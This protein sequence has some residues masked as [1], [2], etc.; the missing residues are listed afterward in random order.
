[1][2]LEKTSILLGSLSATFF[3]FMQKEILYSSLL[4]L[5]V[6]GLLLV[7]RKRSPHLQ[8]GLLALV[9][10]RLLLPPDFSLAVSARSLFDLTNVHLPAQTFWQADQPESPAVHSGISTSSEPP[11]QIQIAAAKV[12]SVSTEAQS[13]PNFWLAAIFFLWVLGVICLS[14]VFL[15][16]YFYYRRVIKQGQIIDDARFL[17]LVQNWRGI[18]GIKRNVILLTSSECL[19]PFT[20]GLWR[21]VIY[22]P[23]TMLQN[24]SRET[25]E[26][27]IAHEMAHINNLD[28]L[29]IKFQNIVQILYFFH[30]IVW[31][32]NSRL[33]E[34]RE[35]LCDERVL[36]FGRITP[37]SYGN[38]MLA[39]LKLNLLGVEGVEMLPSFGNH[40]RKFSLR[41]L[42][43]KNVAAMGRSNPARAYIAL[44]VLAILLLP[45]AKGG[46]GLV[47][48]FD[49]EGFLLLTKSRNGEGAFSLAAAGAGSGFQAISEGQRNDLFCQ[50]KLPCNLADLEYAAIGLYDTEFRK[51]WIL[52]GV[53]SDG[54]ITFYLDTNGDDCFTD[55][56][57]LKITRKTAKY[58]Y[59]GSSEWVLTKFLKSQVQVDYKPY[60]NRDHKEKMA[61][62]LVYYPDR[63]F[64]EFDNI[65][66]WQGEARFGDEVYPVALYGGLHESWFLRPTFDET[67]S[68]QTHNE[69]RIDLNRNGVFEDMTV[70]DPTRNQ[71]MQERHGVTESFQV[72]EER[73]RIAAIKYDGDALALKIVSDADHAL[74][75]ISQ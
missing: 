55:E 50:T 23:D 27:V 8:Y 69:F 6:L 33:N 75:H 57:P 11:P 64:L 14:F 18:F 7:L 4:Y 51:V 31:L 34:V 52:K 44:A 42:E 35:R 26:S 63:N 73:Y 19:S 1:M 13:E 21:P 15:R 28:D 59:E 25:V 10:V 72:R 2:M 67:P 43:I 16:R 49:S 66:F 20:I 17:G 24:S 5:V 30:P 46:G 53:D 58:N 68:F 70:Y 61:I 37:T 38:S 3:E 62:H 65:E 36:S 22:L 74:T 32:A 45:M 29:W 54:Q 39:V 9:F 56:K 40:K 47:A 71:V 60:K 48:S 41:I 12:S